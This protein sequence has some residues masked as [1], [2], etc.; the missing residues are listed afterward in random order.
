VEEEEVVKNGVKK[1]GFGRWNEIKADDYAL[2]NRS[3]TRIKE[4]V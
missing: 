3:T 4:K 2:A 1:F